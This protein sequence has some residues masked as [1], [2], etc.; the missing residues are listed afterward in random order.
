MFELE[1]IVGTSK[2]FLT[3]MRK[4]EDQANCL[5]TR[6]TYWQ[7]QWDENLFL[8]PPSFFHDTTH[9]VAVLPILSI[10]LF[11]LRSLESVLR[12]YACICVIL[13]PPQ[14]FQI[15]YADGSKVPLIAFLRVHPGFNARD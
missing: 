2:Y 6:T 13:F 5:R 4:T 11:R 8:S 9:N 1:E 12:G 15:Q 10:E 14:T 3:E 7:R